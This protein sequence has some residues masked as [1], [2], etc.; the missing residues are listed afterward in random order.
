MAGGETWIIR[1]GR[2]IDPATGRDEIADVLIANGRVEGIG[3]AIGP[4]SAS[5]L[6]ARGKVVAPGL[7]DVHVHLREPGF[8]H[9]E[10]IRTGA[11]AAVAG[12]FTT[13]CAMP[14]TRPVIDRPE[15]VADLL[16]RAQGAACRVLPIG[17]ATVEHENR[18]FTDFVALRDAGCVAITDD[19]FPLQRS[20]DMTAALVR[21]AEADLPFIAHCEMKGLSAGG[22]VDASA[23]RYAPGA[24]TQATLAEAAAVRLWAAAYERAAAQASRPPRLHLAHVSS[25]LG[26]EAVRSLKATGALVTAE[27]APHYLT[28][29]SSALAQF[30]A[31]AKMNPPL[32]SPVDVAAVREAILNGTIDLIATDHAPHSPGEKALPLEEAPFG[33][34]GL[35]TSLAVCLSELVVGCGSGLHVCGPDAPPA[36]G[37]RRCRRPL[38]RQTDSHPPTV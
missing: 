6:E 7:V 34:I 8:E 9:K 16:A 14:N 19:A 36:D 13:V 4:P 30:G 20:E 21:A 26:V 12:G 31:D 11:A 1:G 35:E 24:T 25:A 27:T 38:Q 10:T 32:R 15:R 29:D 33:V 17:A 37:G 5:V 23:A 18:K 2:V 22:A 28:L 3:Q